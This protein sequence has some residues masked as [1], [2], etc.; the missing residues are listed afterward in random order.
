MSLEGGLI[1]DI[2]FK[3]HKQNLKN[4]KNNVN[5]YFDTNIDSKKIIKFELDNKSEI[6]YKDNIKIEKPSDD[7]TIDSNELLPRYNYY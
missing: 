1:D 6:E 7:K 3:N 4:N 2:S 5:I